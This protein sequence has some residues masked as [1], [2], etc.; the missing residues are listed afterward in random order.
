[1]PARVALHQDRTVVTIMLRGSAGCH[2]QRTDNG[3]TASLVYPSGRARTC[4]GGTSAA[5]RK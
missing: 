1:M 4:G 5:P 2:N 3:A